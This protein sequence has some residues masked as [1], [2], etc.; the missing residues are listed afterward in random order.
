[1]LFLVLSEPLPHLCELIFL[2]NHLYEKWRKDL[3]R[4]LAHVEAVIDFADDEDDVDDDLF[5]KVQHEVFKLRDE[6]QRHLEVSSF[7]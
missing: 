2:K 3:L 5:D 6:M 4:A 1:M 7:K